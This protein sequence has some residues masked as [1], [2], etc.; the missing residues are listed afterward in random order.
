MHSAPLRP[1]SLGEIL[2][3]AFVLYRRHWALLVTGG[4][5]ATL[6]A[7]L[8]TLGAPAAAR[9]GLSV[10]DAA[11]L[12]FAATWACG[13][14]ASAL[15]VHQLATAYTTGSPPRLGPAVRAVASR[16]LGFIVVGTI[17]GVMWWGGTLL[18]VVPGMVVAMRY[19]AVIP[20]AVLE[21]LGWRAAR[22]RSIEL[23]RGDEWRILGVV[24]LAM[25][26]YFLPY[27]AFWAIPRPDSVLPM[28][29]ELL[30]GAVATPLVYGVY[31]LLYFDRRVRAE[32]LDVQL[33]AG[34]LQPVA[35]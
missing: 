24:H 22:R 23:S 13:C 20:A 17:Y 4:V 7:I 18:L 26:L 9:A 30:L 1:L 14:L 31:V 3:G 12:V 11:L 16:W 32:G 34:S 33:A 27:F 6:P 35:A 8:A 29:A 25:L 15:A 21:G 19:F 10:D 28:I 2:D 5:L